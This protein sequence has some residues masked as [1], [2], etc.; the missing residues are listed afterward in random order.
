MFG[1]LLR[2]NAHFNVVPPHLDATVSEEVDHLVLDAVEEAGGSAA[3]EHGVGRAKAERVRASLP[4]GRRDLIDALKRALDPD[5][6]LN[7][8]AGAALP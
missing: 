3:G 7:P 4:P 2:S 5:G 1:H 8:G 6:R